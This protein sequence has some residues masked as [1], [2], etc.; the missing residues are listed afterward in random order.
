M[1]IR[2]KLPNI[3]SIFIAPPSVA[4]LKERL[5]RRGTEAQAQIDS[6]IKISEKE[7]QYIEHYDTVIVND[8][9]DDAYNE[10]CKAIDKKLCALQ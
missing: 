9:L 5:L 10:L 7:Q 2:D 4:V 6:R 1:Q 3:L 8:I